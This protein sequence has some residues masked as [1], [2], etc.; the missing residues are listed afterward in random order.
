MKSC[1]DHL[2]I[3]F[4]GSLDVVDV[5]HIATSGMLLL[6]DLVLGTAYFVAMNIAERD[7]II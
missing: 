1:P 3:P 7:V 5:I 6:F 4:S 2:S